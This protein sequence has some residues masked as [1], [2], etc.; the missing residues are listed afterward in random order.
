MFAALEG[1]VKAALESNVRAALEDNVS[2]ALKS[3]FYVNRP[4]NGL[5]EWI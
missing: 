3:T 4:K 5:P 2:A 1:N